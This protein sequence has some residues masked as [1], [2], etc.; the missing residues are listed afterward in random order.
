MP[1]KV[2]LAWLLANCISM[3]GWFS[4]LASDSRR[5]S[6]STVLRGRIT[7]CLG[8]FHIQ[9]GAGK[10]QAV[11]VGGH[12]AQRVAFGHEQDAVEVVADVLHGHGKGDLAQQ[13]LEHLLRHAEGGA[14][15]G[16]FLHQREVFGRQGLQR[17]A[18]LA[19]LEDHLGLLRLQAHGLVA[20]HGRRMSISLRAPTV[21]VKSPASPPS[22][23]VVRIWISRS[24]VVS[25]RHCPSCDQH[26]GQDGQGVRRST[27]PDTDCRTARTLSC[28][29]FRTIMS[30]SDGDAFGRRAS[31]RAAPLLLPKPPFCPCRTGQVAVRRRREISP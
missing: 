12:Q 13:V 20:G 22:S 29:A 8:H 26:I 2:N 19:A 4:P 11:A 25:C 30:T 1:P 28:V 16:G 3:T 17:E 31:G 24:L 18:A 10:G 7:S 23:A 9:R 21:V 14:E 5:C 15:G 27:M 6:S